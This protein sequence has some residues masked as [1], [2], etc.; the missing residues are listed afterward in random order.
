[1]IPMSRTYY[2]DENEFPKNFY[3]VL[4]DLPE[5][6]APYIDPKTKEPASLE[7]MATLFPIELLKQ[8]NNYEQNYIPIPQ[9]L[10]DVYIERLLRPRP[11]MRAT[12][13][14]KELKLPSDVKIFYKREDLS[15]AGS[16]KPN[17]AVAQAYYG[18]KEGVKG[19]A[20]ETGA[21]Q[22]GSSLAYAG[23]LFGMDIEVFMVR[24]SYEQKPYRKIMMNMFGAKVLPSPS[25]TTNIGKKFLAEGKSSGSLGI[26]IAEAIERAVTTG[27]K[28]ALGSVLNH[29]CLHQTIIGLESIAQMKMADETPTHVFGCF[30]GGSNFAGI[31]IAEAIERAVVTGK[32]YSLGSVLNFV[33]LHQTIIGQE[34]TA[35]AHAELSGSITSSVLRITRRCC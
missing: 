34:S 18:M 31:A 7:A 4:P 22:W 14:E 28:Y 10:R 23:M 8:E 32:K 30:G 16:H 1:M 25:D 11:L 35:P 15:P 5:R 29:V 27:K 33:C 6:I 19:Y 21:G 24:C 20:T 3:N 13:L 12:N 2:L 17:T 9:E 26:A